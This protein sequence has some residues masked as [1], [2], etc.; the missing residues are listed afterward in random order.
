[1]L[2]DTTAPWW[3][4]STYSFLIFLTK[5]QEGAKESY[6]SKSFW[7]CNIWWYRATHYIR[8]F[9]NCGCHCDFS[10]CCKKG[11]AKKVLVLTCNSDNALVAGFHTLFFTQLCHGKGCLMFFFPLSYCPLHLK[12]ISSMYSNSL[13]WL[14]IEDPNTDSTPFTIDVLTFTAG[15]PNGVL[16]I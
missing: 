5:Q 6:K 14:K 7:Y 4:C 3:M 15:F 9:S 10:R 11:D 13:F 16:M 8:W 12:M 1:M 2:H